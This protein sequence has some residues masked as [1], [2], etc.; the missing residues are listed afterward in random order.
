MRMNRPAMMGVAVLLAGGLPASAGM[1]DNLVDGLRFAGFVVDG[2]HVDLTNTSVLVAANNMQG[3][4]ID[5]GDFDFA[6]AG[7]V[8]FVLETG[9]RQIQE[10]GITLSTGLLNINPNRVV[11]VGPAQPLAYNFN[12]DAGL[13]DTTIV[14]NMLFDL[15]ASMNS[16][17]S[18]DFRFQASNRQTTNIDGRFDDFP[19]GDADFDIGPIDIEG[20]IFADLLANVTAPFFEAAGIENIFALFSGRVFREQQA[21]A[22]ADTLRA[23]VEAGGSLTAE[24]LA[25]VSAMK[26][27]AGL[28]GDELPDLGFIADG[29]PNGETAST[30]MGVIPEPHTGLLLAAGLLIGVRRRRA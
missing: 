13:T 20:N 24:E 21:R 9:G 16:F 1:F 29:I 17:G 19:I 26:F 10:V 5:L 25:D 28:L 18:Y 3:N 22:T 11:N 4:V 8:T 23:K 6:V 27:V 30:G 7:P 2:T 15:R 12:F 14:G